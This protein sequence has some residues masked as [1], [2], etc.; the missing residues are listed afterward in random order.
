MPLRTSTVAVGTARF[1]ARFYHVAFGAA[2]GIRLELEQLGL[3]QNHFQQFVHALLGERGNVHKNGVATP[4][5]GDQSLVLQLLAHL[6]RIRVRMV[7]LVDG[8][9]NRDLGGFRVTERFEGLGHDAVVRRDDKHDDVRDIR[10]A[11]AHRTER[12][13]A[14]RV[15]ERDLRQF[16]FAF[17]MRHGNRVGAD[18]LRDAAGLARGHIRLADHVEQRGFAVVNM[19]HDG[20]HR[21]AR[22]EL[23]RFVLHVELDLFDRR[24][25][26]PA[27]AFALLHFKTE[28]IFRAK[29]L[30][31]FFVNR[32]VHVGK[33]AQ[34]HQIGDDLERFLLELPRQLA[35]DN[36]RFDDDDFAGGGRDK[37]GLRR[38]SRLGRFAGG[39]R[40]LT[41]TEGTLKGL[42]GIGSLLPA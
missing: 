17:R 9:Q 42:S 21:G 20:D 18:V 29:L 8:H 15:Q 39:R 31:D 23:F 35:H 6:H 37:F 34:F 22:F 27:A 1:N 25:H 40:G 3:Q 19:A 24:V 2:V 32:L 12:R 4:I 11:R 7:A 14:G 36:R 38:G 13:V 5:V 33:N 16:I 28:P 41:T 26:H 10:A 30:G